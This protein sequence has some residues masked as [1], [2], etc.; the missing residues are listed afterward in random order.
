MNILHLLW[1]VGGGLIQQDECQGRGKMVLPSKNGLLAFFAGA[2]GWR[3]RQ[4]LAA[5]SQPLPLL[6]LAGGGYP[7]LS[8]TMPHTTVVTTLI[9]YHGVGDR[10]PDKKVASDRH[11]P[12][13][14]SVMTK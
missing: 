14:S 10:C 3:K 1:C 5:G 7:M 2:D 6:S 11:T 13:P 8:C 4:N 9:Q 12:K